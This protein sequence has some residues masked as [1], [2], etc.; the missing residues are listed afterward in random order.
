M[1]LLHGDCLELMKDIPDNTIDMI[2]CDLPYGLTECAWDKTILDLDKLKTEYL[3]VLKPDGVIALFS[4]QPFTTELINALKPYYSHTWYWVKNNASGGLFCKVQPMR[5]VEEIHIFRKF[6]GKNNKGLY[7]NTREYLIA[8]KEKSGLASKDFKRLLGNGMASHY[9]TMGEQFQLPNAEA[10][11]RLQTT[12]FFTMPYDDLV[13]LYET[14]KRAA[15]TDPNDF[16]YYPQGLQK[17]DKSIVNKAVSHKNVNVY[18]TRNKSDSVQS[19]KGY[20]KNL[21][22]FDQDSGRVHPTQKPIALLEYLIKTY[23]RKGELILDNTMGSGS[24]GVAAINSERDFIGIELD[25]QYFDLAKDRI[26]TAQ[27]SREKEAG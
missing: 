19:H 23:T 9:F 17:L 18:S 2:L 3:R 16:R 21:I 26:T 20:P 13:A 25:H 4:I 15:I 5:C 7:P 10:Y 1:Q 8:E 11:A 24:T 27:L 12:G 6:R 14:E 22:Y